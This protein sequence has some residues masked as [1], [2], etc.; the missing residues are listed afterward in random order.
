M[1]ELRCPTCG[2]EVFYDAEIGAPG[3]GQSWHCLVAHRLIKL[4]GTLLDVEQY[5]ESDEAPPWIMTIDDV[6]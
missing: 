6:R 2:S 1:S 3:R 5:Q 4:G